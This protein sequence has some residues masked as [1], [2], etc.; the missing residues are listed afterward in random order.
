MKHAGDIYAIYIKRDNDIY[1]LKPFYKTAILEQY[2]EAPT[3]PTT[4]PS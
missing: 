4:F 2:C 3:L 1:T